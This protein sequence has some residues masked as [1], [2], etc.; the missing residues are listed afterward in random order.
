MEITKKGSASYTVERKFL[1]KISVAEFVRRIIQSHIKYGS[2][3]EDA[4]V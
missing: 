1:A 3:P 4:A 2:K